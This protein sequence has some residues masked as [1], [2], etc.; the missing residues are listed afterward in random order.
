VSRG[1]FVQI[2]RLELLRDGLLEHAVNLLVDRFDRGRIRLRCGQRLVRRALRAGSGRLGGS[3][4]AVGGGG[5]ARGL[6]RVALQLADLRFQIV[7]LSLDRLQVLATRECKDACRGDRGLQGGGQI[8][9]NIPL[10][11]IHWY[12]K[13]PR[14]LPHSGPVFS[15]GPACAAIQSYIKPKLR[16]ECNK[17]YRFVGQQRR[18]LA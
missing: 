14:A 8:H 5:I 13:T 12:R 7:D 1:A 3:S 4:G 10:G 17:K 9:I 6:R 18:F 16:G 11:L 2:L 15:V